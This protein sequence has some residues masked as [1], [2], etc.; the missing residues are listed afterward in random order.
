MS[1]LKAPTAAG[2]LTPGDHRD[3]EDFFR[4][5]DRKATPSR[6]PRQ[7]ASHAPRRDHTP[8]DEQQ[9]YAGRQ[10]LGGVSVTDDGG[11]LALDADG[12]NR[13]IYA[14][15]SEAAGA[16]LENARGSK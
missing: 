3:D 4:A 10:L 2:A 9:I 12:R 5:L 13:G 7:R 16:V 1:G 15:R 8:S 14:T 6:D 11:F